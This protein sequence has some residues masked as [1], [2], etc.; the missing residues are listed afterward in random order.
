MYSPPAGQGG[1]RKQ[2]RI[3]INVDDGKQKSAARGGGRG[4]F[5]RIGR[6]GRALSVGALVVL[7]LLLLAFIAGLVWWQSY[8]RGPAY[9]LALLVD[10]ARRDDAQA[11]EQLVDTDRVAQ[12]LAP[13]V[14]DQALASVGGRGALPAPRRQIEAALPNLL[15]GMRDQVR[16]EMSNGVKAAASQGRAENMPF[17]MLA[18]MPSLLGGVTE[19]GDDATVRIDKGDNRAAELS[20]KREGERWRVVGLKDDELAA[21]IASRIVGGLSAQPPAPAPQPTPRRRR[22]GQR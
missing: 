8:K 3:V 22:A 14:I 12:S 2:S 6:G 15:A 11:F 16:A 21:G 5:Q 17:F 19:Q 4:F 13:Q 7:G 20:M 10:A 9:T 1:R 18:L